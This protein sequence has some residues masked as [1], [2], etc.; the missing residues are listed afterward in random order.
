MLAATSHV[1][2]SPAPP[3]NASYT[4][5]GEVAVARAALT[6]FSVTAASFAMKCLLVLALSAGLAAAHYTFPA[7]IVNGFATKDWE[8]VRETANVLV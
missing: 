4:S 8:Y 1:Y 6:G 5:K 2:L 7:L 3:C